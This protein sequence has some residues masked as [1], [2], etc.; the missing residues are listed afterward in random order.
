MKVNDVLRLIEAGFTADEVRAMETGEVQQTQADTAPAEAPAEEPAAEAPADAAPAQSEAEHVRDVSDDDHVRAIVM[1]T[2]RNL[3]QKDNA[4][5]AQRGAEKPKTA[6]DI[7]R[8]L[9]KHM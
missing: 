6:E 5:A 4:R 1:Q 9:S 8:E 7:I 3:Q 2:I